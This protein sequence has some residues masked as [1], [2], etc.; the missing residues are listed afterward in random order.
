MDIDSKIAIVTGASSGIGYQT[1]LKLQQK[2]YLVIWTSRRIEEDAEIKNILSKKSVCKNLDVSSE[3]SVKNL[4][5]YVQQTYGHLDV[6]INCAG[7][8]DPENLFSTSLEN[9]EKTIAVNLTGTFL[10]VKYAGL[11]MRKSGGKIVNIASTAGLTPRPGWSAY[12]ASKSGVINFSSAIAE[13]LSEYGIKVFVIAPGRTATPL[14]KILAPNED[15]RTIMQ[16]DVVANMIMFCLT[17][18]ADCIEGQ[19]IL[20]RERF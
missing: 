1:A 13:E 19:P 4:M 3:E 14:R 6:L 9:W 15:P 20:V 5:N 17:A 7:Y 16:P 12:A 18:E 10:C 11:L 8:V 2:G